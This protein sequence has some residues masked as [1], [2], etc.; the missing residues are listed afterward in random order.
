MIVVVY[1]YDNYFLTKNLL[2]YIKEY[3]F[4]ICLVYYLHLHREKFSELFIIF[5]I[6]I[7]KI[8]FIV[9]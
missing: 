1:L 7:F 4:N 3:T 2:L 5:L 8:L 6:K 9:I